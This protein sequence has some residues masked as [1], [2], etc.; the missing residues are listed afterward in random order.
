MN[1]A[2]FASHNGSDLQAIIDACENNLIKANVRI[3]L[4]NNADSMA[5]ERAKT[6]GIDN[7]HVSVKV[8]GDEK[9]LDNIILDILTS[10]E[11]DIIFLPDI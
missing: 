5:L 3:V 10:H 8:Y 6:A 9:L 1:I 7:Y 4:S 2:V 11:I